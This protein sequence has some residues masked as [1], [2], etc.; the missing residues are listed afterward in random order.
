MMYVLLLAWPIVLTLK[1]TG[2]FSS[3]KNVMELIYAIIKL[4][5]YVF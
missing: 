1:H 3:F 5:K 4:V 2:C